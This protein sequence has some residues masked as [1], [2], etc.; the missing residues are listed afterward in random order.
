V[1]L[2][3]GG[4]LFIS[5]AGRFGHQRSWIGDVLT[6]VASFCAALYKVLFKLQVGDANEATVSAFLTCIGIWNLLVMW[7]VFIILNVTD[8]E[9]LILSNMPWTYVVASSVLSL[10]F[11]Y[12]INFGI[13]YQ[14]PLF[15]SLGTVLGI[16][17][18][19]VVDLV[20]HHRKFG[21]EEIVGGLLIIFGFLLLMV[22]YTLSEL[23]SKIRKSDKTTN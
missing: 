1:F 4:V 2:T 14:Y 13:A 6:I 21:W 8:I 22:P 18:S 12:L 5:L 17:L 16:P 19:A 23:F 11:N 15:I 7:P 9:P 10:C 20:W 3:I